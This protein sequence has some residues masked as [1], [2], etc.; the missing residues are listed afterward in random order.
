[1]IL[2]TS[3][4]CLIVISINKRNKWKGGIYIVWN[5]TCSISTGTGFQFPLDSSF[6]YLIIIQII[7]MGGGQLAF[8]LLRVLM[9]FITFGTLITRLTNIYFGFSSSY[10][11]C[12][13]KSVFS[14]RFS[15]RRGIGFLV[16]LIKQRFWF[17]LIAK[18]RSHVRFVFE[19]SFAVRDGCLDCSWFLRCAFL[20][21]SFLLDLGQHHSEGGD[22]VGIRPRSTHLDDDARGGWENTRE[23]GAIWGGERKMR[24]RT[25]VHTDQQHFC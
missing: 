3:W 9:C 24:K 13:C 11:H 8:C 12:G 25:S 23:E 19:M 22:V 1:M 5:G 10:L 21:V 17:K 6:I 2:N 7:W 18:C 20:L 14:G 15:C 16:S 4:R